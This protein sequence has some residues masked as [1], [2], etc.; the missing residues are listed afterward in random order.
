LGQASLVQWTQIAVEG[1]PQMLHV[2]VIVSV[3]MMDAI[4]YG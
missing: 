2:K 4:V 1:S 3:M